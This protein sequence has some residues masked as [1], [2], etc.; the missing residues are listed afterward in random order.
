MLSLVLEILKYAGLVALPFTIYFAVTKIGTKIDVMITWTSNQ[1]C[2]SG[3]GSM[4]LINR[5]DR[6]VVVFSAFAIYDEV[7]VPIS[8]FRPPIILKA[9]EAIKFDVEPVS[10]RTVGAE[11]FNWMMS[12]R[13]NNRRTIH[14][15]TSRGLVECGLAHNPEA[16][17]TAIKQGKKLARSET[18]TF[19]G[20]VYNENVL[21]AVTYT[22]DGNV[23]TAF[24][25]R[26]GF[27][28]WNLIPNGFRPNDLTSKETLREAIE[29][30]GHGAFISPY[31]VDRL[32]S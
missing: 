28:D 13:Q 2:A 16:V 1:T 31:V 12:D 32:H 29:Q 3:I 9:L 17:L 6:H 21:Y 11:K 4:V 8:E 19:N 23:N 30:T 15:S 22:V 18:S 25:L 26:G 14:L 10:R 5:K 27:I 7:I 20:R 24:V